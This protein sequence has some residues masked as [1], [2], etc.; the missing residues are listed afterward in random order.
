MI[1]SPTLFAPCL[2]DP[3]AFPSSWQA[4]HRH[5]LGQLTTLLINSPTLS[6]HLQ[7]SQRKARRAALAATG[8]PWPQRPQRPL[9][10]FSV[11]PTYVGKM[12]A[13]PTGNWYFVLPAGLGKKTGAP[14]CKMLVEFG[15]A[16]AVQLEGVAK[17]GDNMAS[18]NVLC[19]SRDKHC[20]LRATLIP[21][22]EELVE[23]LAE[24]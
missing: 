11:Q 9:K 1:L 21:I 10:L 5:S 4:R 15:C 22:W 23:V 2:E 8:A 18:W 24:Y 13:S 16:F 12:R 6:F 7:A 19:S 3:G 17:S 20:R 14:V